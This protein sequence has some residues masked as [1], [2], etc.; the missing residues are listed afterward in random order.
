M[1]STDGTTCHTL[2]M[3]FTQQNNTNK[4]AAVNTDPLFMLADLLMQIDQREKIVPI[5]KGYNGSELEKL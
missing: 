2:C 1:P 5:P 3:T 4:K